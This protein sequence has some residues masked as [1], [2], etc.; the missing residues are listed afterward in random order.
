VDGDNEV[1][2]SWTYNAIGPGNWHEIY[3]SEDGGAF[4]RIAVASPGKSTLHDATADTSAHAYA[5]KVL[6]RNKFGRSGYSE[7]VNST[8][9]VDP[10]GGHFVDPEAAGIFQDPE[11]S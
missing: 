11:A 1:D 5:Y 3:R 6:A 9:F 4:A 10:E 2:L 8:G 7:T